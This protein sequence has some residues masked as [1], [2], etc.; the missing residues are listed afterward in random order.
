MQIYANKSIRIFESLSTALRSSI[1][2]VGS[3]TY[4]SMAWGERI[5]LKKLLDEEV[6]WGGAIATLSF[7][8]VED[9]KEQKHNELGWIFMDGTLNL[10]KALKNLVSLYPS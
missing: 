4:G 9:D 3:V 10:N 1:V 8:C 5:D 2:V 7:T 6:R